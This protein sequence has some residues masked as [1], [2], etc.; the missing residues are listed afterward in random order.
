[1]ALLKPECLVINSSRGAVVDNEALLRSGLCCALDVWEGEPE[2]SRALLA[3]AV[4]ATPHVAGYTAQGKANASA[5]AARVLSE[6]FD[7]PL[8][9]WYPQEVA[10]PAPRPISWEELCRTID[11]RCDLRAES[12]ILKRM[13][14]AFEAL[15][16]GYHYREEY[17]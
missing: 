9:S 1:M 13:P 14:E 10:P 17:F 2:L 6:E 7:L 12:Q 5:I 3:H 16:D 4:V 15:R 11:A 8:A